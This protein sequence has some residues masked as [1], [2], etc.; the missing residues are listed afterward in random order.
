MD[1]EKKTNDKF[2]SVLFALILCLGLFLR[3]LNLSDTS[4]TGYLHLIY[5]VVA[6]V[7]V[8]YTMKRISG[9]ETGLWAMLLLS[10]CPWHIFLSS[11][12][13]TENILPQLLI[14]ALCFFTY[15]LEK[16]KLLILSGL[17]YGVCFLF[18]PKS[19]LVILLILFTEWGFGFLTKGL[20]KNKEFIL[21]ASLSL[22]IPIVFLVYSL[23]TGKVNFDFKFHNPWTNFTGMM[24]LI[25]NSKDAFPFEAL[26]P[27]GYFGIA[28]S[29]VVFLGVV[30]LALT[31]FYGFSLK[32][33]PLSWLIM[34][35]LLSVLVFSLIVPVDIIL[36]NVVFIPLVLCGSLGITTITGL[37]KRFH[38]KKISTVVLILF[39]LF[40]AFQFHK[41]TSRETYREQYKNLIE[42]ENAA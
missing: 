29:Y 10:V 34:L 36:L 24:H 14:L 12:T 15:G 28:A 6:V 42:T 20:K 27:F 13:L 25:F 33:K 32:K 38:W 41:M 21:H 22:G 16:Q 17:L 3:I 5:S 18:A 2:H 39:F 31:L 30:L 23:I 7:A 8:F 37:L 40:E 19:F 1:S 4:I 11:W 26:E 9:V 35:Q